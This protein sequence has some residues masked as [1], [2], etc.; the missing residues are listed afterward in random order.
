MRLVERHQ[1]SKNHHLY[2]ECERISFLSKNLYNAAL[3]QVRQSFFSAPESYQNY[4]TLQKEFQNGNQIDYRSLPSKVSQ[5]VLQQVEKEFKSFFKAHQSFQENPKKFVGKPKIPKYKDKWKGRNLLVY[6]I[7]AVSKTKLSK[8]IIKLSQTGI[9]FSTKVKAKQ[10]QQVRIVPRIGYYVIEVVYEQKPKPK[11][12]DNQKYAGIDIGVNNLA[13]IVTND[14][15]KP[16]IMNGKPL[17]SMNHYYNQ[18]R[19]KLQSQSQIGKT[20]K[21]E[22][23][24]NKRNNKVE[25]YLHKASQEI[26][27]QIVSRGITKVVIGKNPKWK[28]EVKMGS[29]NNQNFV[30][31]PHAE[32]INKL[33]YKCELEGIEV[34]IQEE[35]YTSKC[36]FLDNEQIRNQE[37]YC[38]TRIK[39]GLF[40]AGSGKIINADVNGAGNILRKAIPNAFRAEGIQGVVVRPRRLVF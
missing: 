25:D 30:Q 27:N 23:L 16:L 31:I 4:E 19:A 39:R 11:K 24:T 29:V 9:E 15:D 8:G 40:K 2:Q 34:I 3:Y 32:L 26:T 10:I 14:G 33:K 37:N 35:S 17:K 28:Q 20:R 13:T 38:G 22:K 12:E 7:Q 36:S 6:T 18:K 21:L 5:H 1:I